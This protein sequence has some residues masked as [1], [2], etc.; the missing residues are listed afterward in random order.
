MPGNGVISARIVDVLKGIWIDSSS[1]LT[2][3][4]NPTFPGRVTF[5]LVD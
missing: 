5:R 1:G 3:V 4:W 2:E